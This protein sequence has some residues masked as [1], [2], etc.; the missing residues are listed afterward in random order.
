[1]VV[2]CNHAFLYFLS[3]LLPFLIC[4]KQLSSFTSGEASSFSGFGRASG[5]GM[6]A[7]QASDPNVMGPGVPE[8]APNGRNVG[9]S[10]QHPIDAMARPGRETVPLP[11]DASSTLYVEGLPPDSTR[12]EV[13]RILQLN[14]DLCNFD[15]R[16]LTHL[17]SPLL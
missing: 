11:P 5:S 8:L 10:G 1:M 15:T 13:A 2:F 14:V 3:F 17:I 7:R 4:L 9:Y 16:I 6:S 12:R